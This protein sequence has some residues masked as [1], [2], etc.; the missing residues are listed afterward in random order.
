MGTGMALDGYPDTDRSNVINS[1]RQW[2]HLMK[3]ARLYALIPQLHAGVSI[4][5]VFAMCFS[6]SLHYPAVSECFL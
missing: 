6:F 2:C 4:K 3:K 1:L 5:M